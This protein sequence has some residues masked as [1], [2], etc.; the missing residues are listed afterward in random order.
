MKSQVNCPKYF[1]FIL[2][3]K[4]VGKGI[5]PS[6]K[7]I[8]TSYYALLQNDK[9]ILNIVFLTLNRLSVTDRCPDKLE[10]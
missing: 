5:C 2:T 3:A 10:K 7:L 4:L 9:D 1:I 8:L 6:R